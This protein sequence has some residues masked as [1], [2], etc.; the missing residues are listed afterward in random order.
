[1]FYYKINSADIGT[2]FNLTKFSVAYKIYTGNIN[3][4]TFESES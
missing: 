2:S 3:C 4:Q 1:M